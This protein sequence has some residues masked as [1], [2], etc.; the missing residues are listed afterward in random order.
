MTAVCN[1]EKYISPPTYLGSYASTSSGPQAR[2]RF[3]VIA[4]IRVFRVAIEV[5]SIPMLD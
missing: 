3:S 4:E 5:A 2:V 1:P